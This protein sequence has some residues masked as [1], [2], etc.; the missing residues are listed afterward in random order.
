MRKFTKGILAGLCAVVGLTAI[1]VVPAVSAPV[2]VE[3][4]YAETTY[5]TKDVAMMGRVAG[6]HGNGNF[7]IRLTLGEADWTEE[8]QKS[9]V[10]AEDLAWA[11]RGFDFFNHIQVGGKT[12]AEWGCTACY[13]NIYW[14]NQSEPDYTLTI[15]LSMGKEI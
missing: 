15:P 2:D 7:E 9:Y 14:L 10:G 3:T 6:W 5:T 12:L 1:A 8:A 11:L 4:A 13:D